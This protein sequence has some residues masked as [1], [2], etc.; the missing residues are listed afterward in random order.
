MRARKGSKRRD[1]E[2]VPLR[3]ISPENSSWVRGVRRT[4]HGLTLA[5]AQNQSCAS[6]PRL[7]R[8][9]VKPSNQGVWWDKQ[10]LYDKERDKV[11][12]VERERL[13][14]TARRARKNAFATNNWPRPSRPKLKEDEAEL[15][16]A[17]EMPPILTDEAQEAP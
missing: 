14:K 2:I 7:N 8:D 12:K 4:T 3:P 5:K 6:W 16:L 10:E 1:L 9:K 13:E 11:E 15:E 17:E